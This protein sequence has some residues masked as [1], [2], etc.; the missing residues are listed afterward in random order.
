MG[1]IAD[2]MINGNSCACGEYFED[3]GPG[4]PRFCS[5]RCEKDFGGY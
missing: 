5:P 3:E 1:E 2:D 4:Y